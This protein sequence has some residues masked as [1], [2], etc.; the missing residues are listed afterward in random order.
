MN[1]VLEG[2]DD[3][4]KSTLATQLSWRYNMQIV[5]SEGPSQGP[6][7]ITERCKRYASMH[8]VIYDRHPCISEPIYGARH[9]ENHPSQELIKQFYEQKPIFIYC[10]PTRPPVFEAKSPC[11]TP[12][13]LADVRNRYGEIL[14][15]YRRWAVKYAHYI[16]RVP[17]PYSYIF[18]GIDR[19]YA[20]S[21]DV[22]PRMYQDLVAFHEKFKLAYNGPPRHLPP[23]L[24]E[25]RSEFLEEELLEYQQSQNLMDKL[26]A[27]V[28]LVYVAIGNAYLHGFPFDVAWRRVHAANMQKVRASSAEDSKRNSAHDVIKPIG[29]QPPD[30]S[31]LVR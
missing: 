28:D 25:F 4:G 5:R 10:E 6:D 19:I 11:D 9:P 8:N 14:E 15:M 1:I 30:L 13:H 16:Y 3:T 17:S 7:E 31:D 21:Q 18:A 27:L 24:E 2:I 12:E 23:E 22:V 26:D 20:P 29:W